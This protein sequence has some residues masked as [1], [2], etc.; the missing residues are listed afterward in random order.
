VAQILNGFA[1]KSAQFSSQSGVP[2]I[3]IRDLFN[4]RTVVNY[5]GE[6]DPRYLIHQGELL[7]GMDGDFNCV[8][9]GGP[10]ALLNQR[11]CRITPN[12]ES[13]DLEYLAA[14]L[15]GYLDAIHA[16]TSSSTVTHLSSRDIERIPI[17]I[18]SLA[19]QRV[20]AELFG[21]A[22]EKSD[23]SSLHSA[24]GLRLVNRCRKSALSY[25]CTGRLTSGWREKLSS[26]EVVN[27]SI[28]DEESDAVLPNT[29]KALQVRDIARVQLGGTPSRKE[30]SFWDGGVPWVSSGEVA[31]ARITSTRETISQ[32][33][34]ERS[35]AKVYPVNTVLI[36]MIG[37][38]KTRGQSAILD[39]EAGTNQN[40]AGLIPDQSLVNPE[41]LWRWALAQYET[42]RGGGRGGVQS[43]LNKEKVEELSIFVPPLEEQVEIVRR[44]DIILSVLDLLSS[45]FTKADQL[46][47]RIPSAVLGAL[48]QGDDADFDDNIDITAS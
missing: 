14:I 11:V 45:R 24:A 48:L 29:W 36:A 2:L 26:S 4:D 39:I 1:F 3:R 35:S 41:Y 23:A 8:R 31:N 25:A 19:E 10:D 38:G 37:E 43:A 28:I 16:A 18:P 33:G 5:E 6:F 12:L 47:S 40:V 30:P 13:L 42:T 15:P 9:W 17:P 44:L 7:V 22:K 21:R 34:L 32:S 20:V 46:S 27:D